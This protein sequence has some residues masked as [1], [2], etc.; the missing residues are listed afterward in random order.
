MPRRTQA[1][2]RTVPTPAV[3]AAPSPRTNA[4]ASA[5]ASWVEQG[6]AAQRDRDLGMLQALVASVDL[7]RSEEQAFADMREQLCSR[8]RRTLTV[9]QRAWVER[10]FNELG[11]LLPWET[12]RDRNAAVPRGREVAPAFKPGPKRPPKRTVDEELDAAMVRMFGSDEIP[13]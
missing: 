10:R 13:Y 4:A 5:V 6:D 1:P 7:R 12:V 3:P 9:A 11:L 2:V 8:A